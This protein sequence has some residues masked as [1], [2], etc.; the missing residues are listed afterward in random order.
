MRYGSIPTVILK[1]GR[2]MQVGYEKYRFYDFISEI[3]Q[4]RAIATDRQ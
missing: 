3:I 2:R 4:E 1:R